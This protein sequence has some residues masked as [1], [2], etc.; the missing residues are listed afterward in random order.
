MDEQR[1]LD[2]Y[3][4]IE[5]LASGGSAEVWRAHDEQLD[6]PVAVKRLHAH[7]L[8]DSASRLRL[9]AEAR[10]AAS[11]SH[12]GIV[13]VYDVDVDGDSPALVMELVEGESLAA[14]IARAGP[15]QPGEAA[16]VAAEVAD[17]LFHAHQQGVIHRDVKP[18]NVLLARDGRARLVD[19]GIAHSLAASAERLTLTGTV[20]GTL[21]SMA[22][23]QLAAGPITPRTDLYGLGVVLHEALTGRAPHPSSTPLVLAEAQRS[24]PPPLD[25]VEPALA[26]LVAACLAYEPENRPQHAGAVAG[27]L[28][29]WLGGAETAAVALG[30]AVGG[31][32]AL[33]ARSDEPTVAE[34][35]AAPASRPSA[36]RRSRTASVALLPILLAAAAAGVG[37]LALLVALNGTGD[38][39]VGDGSPSPTPTPLPAWAHELAA[40]VAESC[41]TAT[42]PT[43]AQE[44]AALGEDAAEDHADALIEACEAAE[45][46][47]EDSNQGRGRGNNGNP[48]GGNNGN[49]GGGNNGNSGR[50]NDR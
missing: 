37:A 25:G 12:P 17:A 18:G 3:R 28:R 14:R 45:D 10:A 42:D 26:D 20:I 39:V 31:G 50:G 29:A 5:R 16:H 49:P 11:L 47:E 46:D 21:R 41:A 8:P 6:R 35:V 32:A 34:S 30:P 33:R 36:S 38:Q 9:A 43:L 24:G 48:G 13:G 4:L 2:R 15:L 1:I 19:F 22:P 44:L 40:D 23:E 7:L 27:A